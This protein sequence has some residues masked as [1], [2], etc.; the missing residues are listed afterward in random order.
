MQLFTKVPTNSV[1]IKVESFHNPLQ[2][3]CHG[4]M[5]RDNFENQ[6]EQLQDNLGYTIT[7]RYA[8]NYY[9][10]LVHTSVLMVSKIKLPSFSSKSDQIVTS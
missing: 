7:T 2:S 5:K 10:L 1:I 3:P 4:V 8:C 6:E 9:V